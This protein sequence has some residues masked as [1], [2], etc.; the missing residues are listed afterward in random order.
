MAF[1]VL[2]KSLAGRFGRHWRITAVTAWV[3]AASL[4]A[5]F[6]Q[7]IASSALNGTVK[8]G[9][10]AALPG[11]TVTITSPALQVGRMATV[12]GEDGS[13][14]FVDLPAGPYTARFELQGFK[15]FT[16]EDLRLTV[17]FV[18]RVDAIMQLG[19]IEESVTVSGQSPVVD[20]TS[21]GASV[22]FTRETLEAVPRG[23]DLQNVF[24]MAPG[25]TQPTP[26]VGG[27]NMANRQ[28]ISSYGVAAQ[29]KLQVE[30]LNVTMGS[31]QSAGVY[32]MD[33]T[34]EE[35]QIKTSGADAEVSVPGISMVGVLKSGGN[36]FHG[37]YAGGF[38]TPKLQASNLDDSLRAQGLSATS[39]LESFYDLAADLGGRIVRD[40]LWFY[41]AQSR[42]K[43]AQGMVG[44][45][46]G[47]GPDG[48]YLTGDESA[49]DFHSQLDQSTFTWRTA[50]SA[51]ARSAA[52]ARK[53]FPSR[54]CCRSRKCGIRIASGTSIRPLR[55]RCWEWSGPSSR[56]MERRSPSRRSAISTS[57]RSAGSPRTLPMIARSIPIRRGRRM[58]R[59]SRTR[60]TKAAISCS[61][62]SA[63]CGRDRAGRSRT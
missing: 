6:A 42:Q 36:E 50:R 34:L 49:A 41:V 10:G 48:R 31:D 25:V 33:N 58:D 17:G 62:G 2:V 60:L 20:V 5:T 26:D 30:G 56:L 55:V 1:R 28:N 23:R 11:V 37:I 18:A 14:R 32:F 12:T 53:R 45:V 27:S 24:A 39:P 7:S 47:P 63:T 9:T 57:W 61:S 54:Q 44:F 16:R 4:D 46:T 8:D 43:R 35:V 29:P 52:A 59:D 51:S 22:A 13:Y 40:R 3:F 15:P 21:T 38:E 19:G